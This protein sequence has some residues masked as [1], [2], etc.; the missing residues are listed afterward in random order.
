[1]IMQSFVGFRIPI[2]VRGLVTML[3]ACDVVGFGVNAAGA[4]VIS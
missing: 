1:M 2:W 4:L 3:P